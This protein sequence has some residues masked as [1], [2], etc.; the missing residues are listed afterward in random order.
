VARWYAIAKTFKLLTLL[1]LLLTQLTQQLTLV[2][3]RLLSVGHQLLRLLLRLGNLLHRGVRPVVPTAP[4][5]S[6]PHPAVTVISDAVKL[7]VEIIDLR[8]ELGD[9]GIARIDLTRLC[10]EAA[11]H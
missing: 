8:L 10:D 3:R 7:A 1:Q 4:S 5:L 9:F 6:H 11:N 2:R